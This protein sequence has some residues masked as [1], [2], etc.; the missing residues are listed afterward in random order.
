MPKKISIYFEVN[1]EESGKR[2]DVIVS[3]EISRVLKNAN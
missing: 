3:K 2:I 1:A